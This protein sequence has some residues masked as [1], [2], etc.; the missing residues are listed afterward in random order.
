MKNLSKI[1]VFIAGC[2]LPTI[3]SLKSQSLDRIIENPA[4]VE[5]SINIQITL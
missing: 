4:V 3:G 2:F 1:T 5:I